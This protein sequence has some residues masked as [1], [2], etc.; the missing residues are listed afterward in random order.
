MAVNK[1]PKQIIVPLTLCA[2]LLS[3]ACVTTKSGGFAEQEDRAKAMET[4]LQLARTYI[5][6]GNWDQA[7]QHLQY[8]ESV[9]KNNPETLAALALVFQNTGEAE[10]AEEYYQR[11]IA[12]APRVMRTRNNYAAFL[13]ERGRYRQAAAQ[14]EVVVED[15]LYER[16][17]EAFINLGRCYVKLDKFREA[18]Q[19]FRRA[20]L[21]QRDEPAVLLALGDV[22]YRLGEYA[23]AQRYYDVYQNMITRPSAAALWLGIRLADK[24]DD[25][26]AH[27][28]NALALKNLFPKSEEYLLYKAYIEQGSGTDR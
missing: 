12:H 19:V 7:K 17:V 1:M 18:E 24:F 3:S 25:K 5:S 2:L 8:V 21:M 9:D 26:N 27:A 10:M 28:S 15:L 20:Y 22:N 6:M 16:R 23:E 14:L 11:S 13:Y 4:S